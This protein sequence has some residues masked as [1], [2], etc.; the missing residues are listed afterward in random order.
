MIDQVHVDDEAQTSN[1]VQFLIR[2]L[3]ML[4]YVDFFS[5]SMASGT[6]PK[7]ALLRFNVCIEGI[8][9]RILEMIQADNQID[10]HGIPVIYYRQHVLCHQEKCR[11]LHLKTIRFIHL[12]VHHKSN[13]KEKT[14]LKIHTL[15]VK[16]K[17]FNPY[18]IT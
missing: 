13:K 7:L 16:K 2:Y 6:R 14:Y 9:K 11:P 18:Y 12:C 10:Q 17:R 4:N 15:N 5:V 3:T 1:W 8:D